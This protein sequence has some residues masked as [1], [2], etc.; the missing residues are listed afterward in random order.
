MITVILKALDAA[1]GLA[2]GMNLDDH[3]SFQLK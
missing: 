1:N 3:C 2:F